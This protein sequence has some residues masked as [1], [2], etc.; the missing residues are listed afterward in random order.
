MFQWFLARMHKERQSIRW[1]FMRFAVGV[2]YQ[3]NEFRASR[4]TASRCSFYHNQMSMPVSQL[5]KYND[6]P[7]AN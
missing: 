1:D 3:Y 6:V 4:W 7:G 2:S 5:T